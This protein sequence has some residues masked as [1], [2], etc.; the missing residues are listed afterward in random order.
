LQL[1][2][3]QYTRTP[4]QNLQPDRCGPVLPLATT[5]L[6]FNP[7]LPPSMGTRGSNTLHHQSIIRHACTYLFIKLIINE[8]H[9]LPPTLI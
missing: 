3:A 5:S 1:I 8:N 9:D 7:L 4:H 2:I 6:D